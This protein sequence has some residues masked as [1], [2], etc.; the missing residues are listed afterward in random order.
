MHQAKKTSK[1]IAETTK[2]K[3][4]NCPMHYKKW[5][6][7]WGTSIYILILIDRDHL[8]F[9]WN[10]IVKTTAELKA[11]F[12]SE[13]KNIST[14]TMWRELKGLGLNSCVALRKTFISEANMKKRLQFIREHKYWALEQWKKVMWSDESRF[15]PFQSDGASE[16]RR[17]KW[18]IHHA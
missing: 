12:N 15:T 10:Q 16:E 6:G 9:W 13:S 17:M 7:Y 3:V 5:E 14:R 18:C 1:E 8:N 4:K 2:I 11:M